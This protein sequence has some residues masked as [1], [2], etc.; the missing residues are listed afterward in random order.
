[1]KPTREPTS[2]PKALRQPSLDNANP[3]R[4]VT[5]D[6][7]GTLIYERDA[8][9][10]YALRA[11]AVRGAASK[12]GVDTDAGGARRALDRAWTLHWDLWHQ[13]TASGAREI[14]VWALADLGVEDPDP[15]E[16]LAEALGRLAIQA[17][18]VALDGARITLE[19]LTSLGVHRALV[20]DTGFSPG[21]LVRQLLDRVGLLEMLEVQIF[22]D[23]AGVPKPHA[24]IFH[25]ALAPLG[26]SPEE[27]VH[28]GDLRHTDIRGAQA[29]GM[30]TIRINDHHDDQS[31]LPDADAVAQSHAEL[32]A[33]LGVR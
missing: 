16:A 25:A 12:C 32:R 9:A 8:G 2:A 20:C 31:P 15:A 23:E 7:W 28:V 24:D 10:T 29:I 6:C 33:I 5:F 18:V 4:A 22:S 17:D 26:V 3:V 14:A 27:A 21:V 19:K 1:M 13:G 11:E 30:G